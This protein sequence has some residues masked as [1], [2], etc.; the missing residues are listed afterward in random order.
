M[1]PNRYCSQQ[2]YI[3]MYYNQTLPALRVLR[4]QS[5]FN[6]PIGKNVLLPSLKKLTFYGNFNQRIGIGVLPDSSEILC[7]GSSYKKPINADILPQSLRELKTPD[8]LANSLLDKEARPMSLSVLPP[9]LFH[10]LQHHLI[11]PAI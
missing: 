1:H 2:S 3:W 9:W 5:Q 4:F 7:F 8:H 10:T 11:M 6:Q